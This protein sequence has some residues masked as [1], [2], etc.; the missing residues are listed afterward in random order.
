MCSGWCVAVQLNDCKSGSGTGEGVG[1]MWR[2]APALWYQHASRLSRETGCQS[3]YRWHESCSQMSVQVSHWMCCK[4]N[5][6]DNFQIYPVLMERWSHT[7][8]LCKSSP[9]LCTYFVFTACVF[10]CEHHQIQLNTMWKYIYSIQHVS[11]YFIQ[12]QGFL[13]QNIFFPKVWFKKFWR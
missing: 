12:L 7:W 3:E 11:S 5:V 13:H 2:R 9:H 6:W 10:V 4:I 1:V 8:Y